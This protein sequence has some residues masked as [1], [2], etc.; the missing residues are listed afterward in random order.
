M[1]TA[2]TETRYTAEDL[3][4]MPDEGRYELID[5]VLVERK[6]GAKSSLVAGNLLFFV[7]AFA[8]THS[9]GLVFLPDCGYQVFGVERDRVRYADGSFIRTGRLPDDK[10]PVGHVRIAPDL[11]IEAVSSNDTAPEVEEKVEE[12]LGAGVPLVWVLYPNTHHVHIHR[13]DGT[14]R[15]LRSNDELS[16]ES[17]LPGFSCRA[18]EIFQGV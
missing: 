3:L 14:V 4:A 18:S 16:G 8:R 17:I 1:A 11:V 6:M 10:P 2:G 13:A 5:G 9:L 7:K 12:W 15:K